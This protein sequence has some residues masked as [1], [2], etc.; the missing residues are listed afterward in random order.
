M[1]DEQD[2]RKLMVS[3]RHTLDEKAG[4]RSRYPVELDPRT[5]TRALSSQP[6]VGQMEKAIKREVRHSR[7]A[8]PEAG[9]KRCDPGHGVGDERA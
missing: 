1:N 4:F 5:A 2:D 8:R 7:T 6:E 3:I 9:F